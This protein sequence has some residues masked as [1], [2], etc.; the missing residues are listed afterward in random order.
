MM[1]LI[2]DFDG[3]ITQADTIGD[4]AH[5]GIDFQRRHGHDL[6]S[7]WDHVVQAYTDDCKHYKDKY[8]TKEEDRRSVLEEVEYLAGL[9]NVEKASLAR[10]EESGIFAGLEHRGLFQ[11][12]VDAIESKKIALRDGFREVLDHAGRQGW[13]VGV[14]SVNWSR[15]FIRGVLHHFG[16]PVI[17]ANEISPDGKIHGPDYLGKALTNS[18]GKLHVLESEFEA[19]LQ[20]PDY[21][22]NYTRTLYFGDSS[23]DLECLLHD[24]GI[25]ISDEDDSSLIRT[26]RRL[27]YT[28]SHTSARKT[29]DRSDFHWARNFREVL[30]SGFLDSATI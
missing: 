30:D 23:T 10:V 19:Q 25:I 12:G 5:A 14:I 2:F 24:G 18:A 27:G 20:S 28:V 1:R 9:E 3:T 4:L 21:G 6:T 8:P 15:S 13:T 17:V 7:R 26:I 16:I 11:M 22:G 29:G